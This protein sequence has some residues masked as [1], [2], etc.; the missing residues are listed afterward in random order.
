SDQPLGQVTGQAP[1]RHISL[2]HFKDGQVVGSYAEPLGVA[3]S[4]L[5]MSAATCVAPANCWFAGE[6][7][8]GLINDGAFHLHWDGAA[9]PA[10]PSV[11][12]NQPQIADPGR[13]VT[14]LAF[15]GGALYDG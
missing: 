5:P 15:Y 14:S 13:T 11:T 10:I 3:G 4:Y 8:P 12:Q 6:R 1:A 2:C 7:L 9:L